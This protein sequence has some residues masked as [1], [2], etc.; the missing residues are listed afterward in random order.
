M[1]IRDR[2]KTLQENLETLRKENTRLQ[3]INSEASLNSQNQQSSVSSLKEELSQKI[4]EIH[5]LTKTLDTLKEQE[6]IQTREIESLRTSKQLLESEKLEVS[7]RLSQELNS[8]DGNLRN[9]V[10]DFRR[11]NRE[12]ELR[13]KELDAILRNKQSGKL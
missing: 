5:M 11:K 9:E 1:C 10:L 7:M 2:N 4:Q 8:V 13:V 6:I 12:L 3:Q